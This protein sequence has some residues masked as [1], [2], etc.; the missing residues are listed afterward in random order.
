MR[1]EMTRA[2]A[3][4][5][6][7]VKFDKGWTGGSC[8]DLAFAQGQAYAATHHG[9]VLRLDAR[10][11]ASTWKAPR[12]NSGLPLNQTADPA[13]GIKR[14][15]LARVRAV[16]ADPET[17]RLLA[18]GPAGVFR[19]DDR[20][21]A[22]VVVSVRASDQVTLPPTWLFCPGVHELT[23]VTEHESH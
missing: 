6:D 16:A 11:T 19:S 8:Y 5:D 10:S 2:E 1:F 14:D 21:E 3:P 15:G 22:Y 13:A 23:V 20:G 12:L 18:G 7:W 4:P 9:G 17:G